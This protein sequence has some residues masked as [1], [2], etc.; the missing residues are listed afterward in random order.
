MLLPRR[1]AASS[2][3]QPYSFEA[4]AI[5]LFGMRL[6]LHDRLEQRDRGWPDL[7]GLGHDPGGRPL[8]VS[9]MRARHV[10]RNRGVPVAHGRE[11]VAGDARAALECRTARSGRDRPASTATF[12][13][14]RPVCWSVWRNRNSTGP[15]AGCATGRSL[16]AL[17]TTFLASYRVKRNGDRKCN[18]TIMVRSGDTTCRT[19]SV[20][21]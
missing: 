17:G 11:G 18:S 16:W 7:G 12:A 4:G 14:L 19:A 8:G 6:R 5:P 10:L 13:M 1:Q 20:S 15:I 2:R 3:S 9:P 21:S